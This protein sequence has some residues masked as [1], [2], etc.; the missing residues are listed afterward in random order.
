ME[1]R[2]PISSK[3]KTCPED[4]CV[5]VVRMSMEVSAHY[6]GRSRKL[7]MATAAERRREGRKEG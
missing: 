6:P 7:P 1:M 4:R 5:D 2:R 3:S